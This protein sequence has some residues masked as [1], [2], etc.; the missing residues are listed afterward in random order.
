MA[1]KPTRKHLLISAAALLLGG[2][3][4]GGATLGMSGGSQSTDDA[5]VAADFTQV[6]PRVSGQIVQVLVADNQR[7]KAGQILA[8]ID[9]R[10]YRAAL[11]SAEADVAAAKAEVANLDAEIARHPAMVAQAQAAVR[12][13]QAGLDFAHANATRYRDLSS[14]GAGT[15]QE[16]QQA[17]SSFEQ[18][19]AG[20]DRDRAALT[21]TQQQIGVLQAQRERAGGALARALAALDQAKLNL[22]YTEIH[23]PIDGMVGQRTVRVGAYVNAGAPLLAVVPLAQ[24]YVVANFQENQLA[25]MRLRQ[26]AT[27]RIDSLP[28]VELKAHVDSLAPAT[29]VTFA[30]IAPDNATGNFTKVVQ[31]LP[32]KLTIDPGQADA[33]K[34]HVG[35]SVIPSVDIAAHGGDPI[36]GALR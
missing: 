5:Y 11:A 29:A 31:R 30:P 20:Q 22:S 26:P 8:R 35:L 14:D 4:V 16:Q 18:Q 2:V 7:V 28:D 23:A 6:A 25:H 27:I 21:A 17:V 36:Q 13:D 10:D 1:I 19:Q 34:L 32:V 15:M 12:A 3:A 33:R 24:A 9:D